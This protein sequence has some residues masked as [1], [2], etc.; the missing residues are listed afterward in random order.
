[1]GGSRQRQMAPCLEERRQEVR[2]RICG[3]IRHAESRVGE[4]TDQEE[5]LMII[6]YRKLYNRWK[7]PR[8]TTPIGRD[9]TNG[10]QPLMIRTLEGP[11]QRWRTKHDGTDRCLSCRMI[12]FAPEAIQPSEATGLSGA[13]TGAPVVC[14]QSRTG[15]L[16]TAELGG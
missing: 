1:M 4:C 5:E 9:V 2:A 7:L 6:T 13:L 11:K 14:E 12:T 10:P 3:A 16:S 8:L 15:A